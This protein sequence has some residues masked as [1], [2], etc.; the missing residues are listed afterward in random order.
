MVLHL[1][2]VIL[3]QQNTN[4]AIHIS[5]KL[6]PQVIAF[7]RNHLQSTQHSKL[8]AL[9]HL[10]IKEHR[11]TT[12]PRK[13]SQSQDS[14][15]AELTVQEEDLDVS[16]EGG[17]YVESSRSIETSPDSSSNKEEEHLRASDLA[18]VEVEQ[19]SLVEDLKKV[20][21]KPKGDASR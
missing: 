9:E 8:V 7:L 18:F 2:T 13:E 17:V 1:V 16:G 20:V 15:E 4:C 14:T 11:L 5:G 3:F 10:V 19:R 12:K 21:I 6:L